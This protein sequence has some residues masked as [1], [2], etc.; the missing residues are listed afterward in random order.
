[1][2]RF[3]QRHRTIAALAHRT[4]LRSWISNRVWREVLS[5][6]EFVRRLDQGRA[7]LA[8]GRVTPFEIEQSHTVVTASNDG[9]TVTVE[10]V[11]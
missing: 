5:D 8:A 7:D 2:I 6:P 4:P 10:P 11:E 9:V 3:V 1:M